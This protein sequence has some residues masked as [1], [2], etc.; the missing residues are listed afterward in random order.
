MGKPCLPVS[1]FYK[2]FLFLRQCV[3]NVNCFDKYPSTISSIRVCVDKKPSSK[4][5]F[6]MR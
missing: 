1:V 2:A 6:L 5:V 4:V 3:L